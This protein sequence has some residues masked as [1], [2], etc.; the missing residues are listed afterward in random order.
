MLYLINYSKRNAV[1]FHP[2]L[3]LIHVP[4]HAKPR[5]APCR[6]VTKCEARFC[7]GHRRWG[8]LLTTSTVQPVQCPKAMVCIDGVLGLLCCPTGEVCWWGGMGAQALPAGGCRWSRQA[9]AGG[10]GHHQ[11]LPS[12]KEPFGINVLK[13]EEGSSSHAQFSD[14]MAEACRC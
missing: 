1:L 8:L 2:L 6:F 12:L 11:P 3:M 4:L 10:A 14:T 7:S 13:V 9:L 5:D